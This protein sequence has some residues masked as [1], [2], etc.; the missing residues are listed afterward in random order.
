MLLLILPPVGVRRCHRCGACCLN[1]DPS[2]YKLLF[3]PSLLISL[4]A[5]PLFVLMVELESVLESLLIEGKGSRGLISS[6]DCCP[7]A[8]TRPDPVVRHT[9]VNS[10]VQ[11]AEKASKR[12]HSGQHSYLEPIL[13]SFLGSLEGGY[14][15]RDI[16]QSARKLTE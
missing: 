16:I 4:V 3:G 15:K 14:D 5:A 9:A 11:K 7:P 2:A 12:I 6:S 13:A 8:A 10:N 1:D